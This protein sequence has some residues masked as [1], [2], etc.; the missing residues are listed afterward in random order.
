MEETQE[1]T[2]EDVAVSFELTSMSDRTGL[3]FAA[4]LVVQLVTAVGV[5]VVAVG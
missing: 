2:V 1:Q 5:W 4:L 3:W